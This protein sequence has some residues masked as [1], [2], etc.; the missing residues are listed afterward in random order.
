MPPPGPS[1]ARRLNADVGT[2][3][4]TV[5]ADDGNG[6]TVSD[7]FDIV[8]SNTND[9]PTVANPI[10]DQSATEDAAFSFPLRPTRSTTSMSATR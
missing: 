6:G 8:V 10:A 4:V 5:T 2:V 1:A 9:A 3:T 7:T